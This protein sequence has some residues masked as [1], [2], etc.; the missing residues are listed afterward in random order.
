MKIAQK[1]IK[2]LT[3]AFLALFSMSVFAIDSDQ[4][5]DNTNDGGRVNTKAEVEAYILHH[6]K[7]SHDF[8][9]WSIHE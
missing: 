9:L 3:I 8:S 6:I 1:P 7:D 5:H 2:F 4:K